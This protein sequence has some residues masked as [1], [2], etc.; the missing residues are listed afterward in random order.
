MLLKTPSSCFIDACELAFGLEAH[1]VAARMKQ[2]L[3][4]VAFD[5][6]GYVATVLNVASLELY[7]IGLSK[8][9]MVP[10]IFD[11][12]G[13]PVKLTGC[14]PLVT[15]VSSWFRRPGFRCVAQGPRDHDGE[16]HANAWN[17]RFWIDPVFPDQPIEQ[18]NVRVRTLWVFTVPPESAPLPEESE[19]SD[20][21]ETA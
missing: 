16:E 10:A 11:V 12:D 17:G 7:K 8:I 9:D 1:V 2:I 5:E 21:P 18:P 20:P 4:D 13:E 3:P 14:D 15:H 6:V 19:P